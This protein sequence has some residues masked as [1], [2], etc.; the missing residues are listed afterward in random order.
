[1]HKVFGFVLGP[2]SGLSWALA[3]IFL[4][5]TIRSLLV[6]PTIKQMRSSRRMQEMQPRMQELRKK[7]A[8]DQQRQALELRKLQKEMG[9]N[10]LASCLPMLVQ[11]PIFLGLFHVLRSFNRTGEGMGQLGMTIEETRNTPNYF[12]GVD[13]VQSF[14]D[15]R[16]FGTPLSGFISMSEDAF[17][18]FSADGSVDFAR[19]NII[20]V[21]LP[22][23]A[24][25]S[26]LM[27]FNARMSMD[28][29][30]KRQAAQPKK[31][32]TTQQDMM[33]NQMMMMQK[34]MLWVMPVMMFAGGFLWQ[35]GLAIYMMANMAWMFVQQVLV[36][37]KM[38]R[39][40]EEEREAKLAAKR[41]SAPKPGKKPKGGANAGANGSQDAQDS[42]TGGQAAEGSQDA[43]DVANGSAAS[44]C[45]A[46]SAGAEGASAKLDEEQAKKYR[47]Q[48]ESMTPKAL[49][50]AIARLKEVIDNPPSKNQ[51]KKRGRNLEFL[52][53][54]EDVKAQPKG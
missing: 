54:L 13:E 30:K 39:E 17:G 32:A 53:I 10:P 20:I 35:V 34:L 1:W 8:N 38:D 6:R 3:I 7:Y 48:A 42:P 31:N 11:I 24:I 49:D 26:V 12:F 43:S 14:L 25:A 50:G 27:H 2:D 15:A 29:Q 52:A 47:A 45:S 41:T 9:V 23:M 19:W 40:E 44:A 28:R 22:L 46:A 18:A 37:R 5:V 36:F 51:R 21:V 4:L 16:L 33:Q